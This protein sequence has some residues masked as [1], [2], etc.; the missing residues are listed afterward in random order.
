[1]GQANV[2]LVHAIFTL[3]QSWVLQ[4]QSGARVAP[5]EIWSESVRD[6]R[7]VCSEP[8]LTVETIKNSCGNCTSLTRL[9]LCSLL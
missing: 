1:M 2:D 8:I 5:S 7:L 4:Y 3:S 6:V 9:G